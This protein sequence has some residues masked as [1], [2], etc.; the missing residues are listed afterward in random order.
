MK[1]WGASLVAATQGRIRMPIEF[2]PL[3]IIWKAEVPFY[4]EYLVYNSSQM[5][6]GSHLSKG[7]D[8]CYQNLHILWHKISESSSI[9][10]TFNFHDVGLK[11]WLCIYIT[12]HGGHIIQYKKLRVIQQLMC[13]PSWWIRLSGSCVESMFG[14]L[15][16]YLKQ[17]YQR[18]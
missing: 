8:P 17:G 15:E 1:T 11:M 16:L 3:L 12:I 5:A 7:Q 2:C 18:L 4:E 6:T 10:S 13:L 14:S 9:V